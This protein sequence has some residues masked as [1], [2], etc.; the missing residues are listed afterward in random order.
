MS[1]ELTNDKRR[2]T[3]IPRSL[4]RRVSTFCSAPLSSCDRVHTLELRTQE[5]RDLLNASPL[6]QDRLSCEPDP[7]LLGRGPRCPLATV[8]TLSSRQTS[9]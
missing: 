9:D 3:P 4:P 7:P 2:A 6:G 1:N 5:S 8:I